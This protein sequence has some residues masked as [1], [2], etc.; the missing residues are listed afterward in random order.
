MK[1]FKDEIPGYIHNAEIA[2]SLSS[3]N[4]SPGLSNIPENMLICYA[5]LIELGL[6]DPG[7]NQLLEAWL[8]DLEAMAGRAPSRIN[9][10]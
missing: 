4:L 8:D 10:K 1:D 9:S 2:A 3:L 6:I 7:E 5:K